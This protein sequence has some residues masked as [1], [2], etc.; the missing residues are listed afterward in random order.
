VRRQE[1]QG[2]LA[3]RRTV[4]AMDAE[5]A[6]I[7]AGTVVQHLVDRSIR[8]A[9]QRSFVVEA[10]GHSVGLLTLHQIKGVPR[11]EWPTTPA[12]R[13]MIPVAR[14][15]SI[16]PDSDLWSVLQEMDRSGVTQ[17]PVMANGLIVG[18]LTREGIMRFVRTLRENS[19]YSE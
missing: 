9:G 19:C 7:G 8:V 12:G 17:L 4:E 2:L 15:K 16:G 14:A 5:P 11:S 18:M 6:S 1:I 3:G 13:I 10:D